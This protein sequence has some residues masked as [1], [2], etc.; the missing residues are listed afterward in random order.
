MLSSSTYV[1]VKYMHVLADPNNKDS[2]F[3]DRIKYSEIDNF[4]DQGYVLVM[5]VENNRSN[6][7]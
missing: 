3:A 2:W 7:Q 6:E 4:I 1:N 5:E